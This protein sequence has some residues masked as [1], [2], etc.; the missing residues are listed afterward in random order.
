MLRGLL[1]RFLVVVA[2]PVAFLRPFG[3]MLFYLWYSHAR[4]N[5]FV[6][7]EYTFDKGAYLLAIA[8]G[9]GYFLFEMGR[10]PLRLRGLKLLPIFWIWIAIA[11]V[12]AADPSLAFPKLQQYAHIFVITF[13]IAAM[14]NSESRISQ[15]LYVIAISIGMVGAKGAVDFIISGGQARMRGPGGL[16]KEENEFALVLNMAIPMLVGLASCQPRKWAR[17]L[18]WGMALGCAITVVG[19]RSRSGFLGLA[20]AALLLTFYSKRKVLGFAALGLAA[21]AFLVFAP[22]KSM[23]RYESIST[24]AEVDP[25]AIGRLQAWK[26]GLA[27]MKAHPLFGVGPL[28]FDTTFDEYSNYTARAPH[29]AFVALGAESGIPSCLLFMGILGS[30]IMQMRRLRRRLQSYPDSTELW[31][32]CLIIQIT[33]LVY[34]VPNC[35]INR[36]NLDLMYHLVG[37]SAGLALVAKRRLAEQSMEVASEPQTGA[38][39]DLELAQA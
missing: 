29:N 39:N 3:G 8:I 21:V 12:L 16:M 26:T 23:H 15:L 4:P 31:T 35:F 38:E 11:T 13:L 33:L 27:M 5:D 10:S 17:L 34:I 24:A 7:P 1:I 32:Y 20:T 14:A 19:T 37:I 9:L 6:W 36:Q 18:L 2:L 28:N 25:S 22:S 30:A